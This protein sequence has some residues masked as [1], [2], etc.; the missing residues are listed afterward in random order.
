[1]KITLPV[2]KKSKDANISSNLGRAPYFLF[3]DTE[4]EEYNF[5][6][7]SA[8]SSQGGAGIKAAQNILDNGAEAIIA[9]R[10][11]QNAANVF[12]TAGIKIYKNISNSIS[13]NI[14]ALKE[15]KL[16]PLDDIHP[17]FHQHGGRQ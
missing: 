7:N 1:M 3:Y 13:E 17:G 2:D 15:G 5:M 14:A 8:A 4:T 16:T 6:D 10:C 9:P 12:M 11:G